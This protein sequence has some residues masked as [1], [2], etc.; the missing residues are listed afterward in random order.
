M[1]LDLIRPKRS[2]VC[3]V[4]KSIVYKMENGR[5]DWLGHIV[6][7]DKKDR[8]GDFSPPAFLYRLF[9]SFRSPCEQFFESFLLKNRSKHFL[10]LLHVLT[11]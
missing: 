4:F 9:F 2:C 5:F 10:K 6:F 1:C 7:V 3:D 11:E 8:G